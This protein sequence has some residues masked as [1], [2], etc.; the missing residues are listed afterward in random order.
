MFRPKWSGGRRQ[1]YKG[2]LK[3]QKIFACSFATYSMNSGLKSLW[4]WACGKIFLQDNFCIS[5]PRFLLYQHLETL[6]VMSP[7]QPPT[8]TALYL[9]PLHCSC[10]PQ[11]AGSRP[12]GR[13]TYPKTDIILRAHVFLS[14]L[15]NKEL[16]YFPSL[17]LHIF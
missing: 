7:V 5:S 11:N 12:M 9:T 6:W 17:Q 16:P 13:V 15:T 3:W 14:L 2:R 4:M 1:N 8:I 10:D